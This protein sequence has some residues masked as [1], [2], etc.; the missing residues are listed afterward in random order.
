MTSSV[1]HEKAQPR[2]AFSEREAA[3][4]ALEI[5]GLSRSVEELT[6]E[7]DQNFHI[8]TVSGEEFVLKIAAAAERR[9]TLEFQNAVMEDVVLADSLLRSSRLRGGI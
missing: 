7:R 1:I 9:E 2:P 8:E 4:L 3:R 5:Y 6:S